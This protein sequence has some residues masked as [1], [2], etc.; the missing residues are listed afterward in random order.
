MFRPLRTLRQMLVYTPEGPSFSRRMQRSCVLHPLCRV[1]KH[2][3]RPD[4]EEPQA[5]RQWTLPC[6]EKWGHPNICLGS[7][8]LS[9]EQGLATPSTLLYCCI[10]YT[11]VSKT[12]NTEYGIRKRGR[13]NS[14][15]RKMAAWRVELK[16]RRAF[17]L[18]GSEVRIERALNRRRTT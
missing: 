7:A 3:H 1:L 15:I 2:V 17:G 12:R 10:F 9:R 18:W 6:I 4:C 13:R 16:W 14:G 8:C 5:A 11:G